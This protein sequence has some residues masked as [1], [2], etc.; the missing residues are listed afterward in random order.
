M[1]AK[2]KSAG[3]VVLA[4]GSAS[5]MGEVKQLLPLGDSTVLEQTLKKSL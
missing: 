3:A 4:A 5:R 2:L 1:S